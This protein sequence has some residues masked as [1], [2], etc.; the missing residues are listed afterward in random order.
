MRDQRTTI[1]GV[2][3]KGSTDNYRA[4]VRGLVES[5]LQIT[6][7][8]TF[9]PTQPHLLLRHDID[10]DVS[11]ALHLAQNEHAEGWRATYFVMLTSP[12][13]N[14]LASRTRMELRAIADLG[15]SIGL[16][17][18]RTAAIHR[19]L[20]G[21]QEEQL[22]WVER[23]EVTPVD[24]NCL[25]RLKAERRILEEVVGAP[26]S[27]VTPHRP[28]RFAADW[29][30]NPF[31]PAGMINGYA[32]RYFLDPCYLS[33]SDG[34]WREGLPLDAWQNSGKSALHLL[35]HPHLWAGTREEGFSRSICRSLSSASA[36]LVES[37]YEHFSGFAKSAQLANEKPVSDDN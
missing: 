3:I 10:M 7:F 11:A 29:L 37:A 13:Y 15:H 5:G 9:D 28:G 36:Y 25:A 21:E 24:R 18:D 32:P 33:D 2:P 8:D 23:A 4:L 1:H 31:A 6:G 22:R 20:T 16:H 34:S 12:F 27:F 17:F 19:A 14:A 35:T 30:G 26:V